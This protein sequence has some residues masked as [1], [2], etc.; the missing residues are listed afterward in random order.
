[1]RKV[2]WIKLVKKGGLA[3]EL[4]NLPFKIGMF[5]KIKAVVLHPDDDRLKKSPPKKK[6]PQ[7]MYGPYSTM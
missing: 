7:K 1:M 5:G 4:K 2:P 6:E 3:E